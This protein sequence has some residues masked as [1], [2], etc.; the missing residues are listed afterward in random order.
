MKRK[1]LIVLIG[2]CTR[3]WSGPGAVT[4]VATTAPAIT[5]TPKPMTTSPMWGVVIASLSE[6][7]SMA[8][9]D[10]PALLANTEHA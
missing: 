5:A 2:A 1:N 6:S 7:T 9:E 10:R 4:M 8:L 3:R